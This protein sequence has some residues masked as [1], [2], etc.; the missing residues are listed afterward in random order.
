M[1]AV[2][3]ERRR[4]PTDHERVERRIGQRADLVDRDAQPVRDRVVRKQVPIPLSVFLVESQLEPA[5]ER[6]A[7]VPRRI[8]SPRGRL[9]FLE[10]LAHEVLGGVVGRE[11]DALE[12]EVHGA[13]SSAAE[14]DGF[15]ARAVRGAR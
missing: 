4:R 5:A 2:R 7:L 6:E 10:H 8:A 12:K 15:G 11:A 3:F 1:V 13:E 14:G 9:A